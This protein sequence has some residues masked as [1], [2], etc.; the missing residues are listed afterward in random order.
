MPSAESGISAK[1][2]REFERL[3]LVN[4]AGRSDF[5]GG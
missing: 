3:G 1:A 5:G 4:S 2:I